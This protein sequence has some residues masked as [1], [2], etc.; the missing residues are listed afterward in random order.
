VRPVRSLAILLF[1]LVALAVAGCGG[2]RST[3]RAGGAGGAASHSIIEASKA[4]SDAGIPFG[5][6]VTSNPYVR[7]QQ[8]YL[9]GKLNG[10]EL[11]SHVLAQLSGSRLVSRT[12]W[13][14]WVFDTDANAAGA[15]KTMPLRKWGVSD[16][17]VT[18]AIDGNVIVVASNFSGAQKPK[19]DAALAS[20]H[21]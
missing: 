11:A 17:K 3:G 2:E 8:V 15:V 5:T 14:A 20:L 4:F 9:P 21:G 18:R 7:G 16:S 1:A 10:S 12:G 13:V 6:L 19:L